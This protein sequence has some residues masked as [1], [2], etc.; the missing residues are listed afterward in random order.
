MTM[1]IKDAGLTSEQLQFADAHHATLSGYCA[2]DSAV[3]LYRQQPGQTVR[4]IIDRSAH[5]LER[6][7]FRGF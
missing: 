7:E 3:R 2:D 4:W 1:P 5:V 6:T